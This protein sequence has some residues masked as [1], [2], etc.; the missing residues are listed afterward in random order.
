M[1]GIFKAYDV[2]GIY[3]G[4]INE[5]TALQIGRAF[6]HVLDEDDRASGSTVVVSRDMRSHSGPLSEA[7]IRGPMEAGMDVVST[8]SAIST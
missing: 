5:E 2:R 4:E 8:S 7:L 3:P 1:A 6:P